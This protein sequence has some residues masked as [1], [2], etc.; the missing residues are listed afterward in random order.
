MPKLKKKSIED[1]ILVEMSGS[2]D[3]L[4]TKHYL[5][6]TPEQYESDIKK[7][8]EA[9]CVMTAKEDIGTSGLPTRSWID[10]L[11]EQWRK[12]ENENM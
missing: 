2:V 12:G 6:T 8:F 11:Y 3:P 9:G 1:Y 4:E 10:E 7:A 5:L